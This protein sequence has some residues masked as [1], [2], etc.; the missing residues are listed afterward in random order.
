MIRFDLLSPSPRHDRGMAIFVTIAVH[1]L[2]LL[3]VFRL[4]LAQPV[5]ETPEEESFE[6]MLGMDEEGSGQGTNITA[7]RGQ[8]RV[9]AR[10]ASAQSASSPAASRTSQNRN[11]QALP[12]TD[13]GVMPNNSISS[14]HPSRPNT[15][16]PSQNT[17]PNSQGDGSS[18]SVN[19]GAGQKPKATFGPRNSGSG[20]GRGTGSGQ[21]QGSGTGIQG[22]PS[23]SLNYSLAA[24]RLVKSP[25]KFGRF[26]TNGKVRIQIY[27]DRSGRIIRHRILSSTAAELSSIAVARL[28]QVKFNADS[29]A[30]P[31]QQGTLTFKFQLR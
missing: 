4:S 25:S 31:E 16:S 21:G 6:V 5:L 30:P 11:Y 10:G 29:K 26:S 20:V 8:S 14:N 12:Q 22:S 23:G 2:L 9:D 15:S 7:Q 17:A 1:L 24:R 27:V 28:S 19:T 18:S 13:R 3:I